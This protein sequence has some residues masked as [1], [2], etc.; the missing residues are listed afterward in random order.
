MKYNNKKNCKVN[1]CK[2]ITGLVSDSGSLYF[3]V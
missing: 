2:V 3:S 1:T